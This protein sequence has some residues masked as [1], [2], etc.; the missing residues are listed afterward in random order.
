M[1]VFEIQSPNIT[2]T[3]STPYQASHYLIHYYNT[4]RLSGCTWHLCRFNTPLYWHFI[5]SRA[6]SVCHYQILFSCDHYTV[7]II[8]VELVI[9]LLACFFFIWVRAVIIFYFMFSYQCCNIYLLTSLVAAFKILIHS[10]PSK[11][12]SYH[13]AS[14]FS[15]PW[16][17]NINIDC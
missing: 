3:R 7:W 16:I 9:L 14:L 4:C 17:R 1:V 8:S 13:R 12:S 6:V 2:G 5:F 11:C 10:N 15:L